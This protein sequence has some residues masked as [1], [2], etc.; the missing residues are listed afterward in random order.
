CSGADPAMCQ[1]VLIGYSMGGTVVRLQVTYSESI[2]WDTFSR[3]PLDQIK[4]P[5]DVRQRLAQD[6]YFEPLPFVTEAIY[7]AGTQLGPTPAAAVA[8]RIGAISTRFE[9]ERQQEFRS[10]RRENPLTLKRVPPVFDGIPSSMDLM[11]RHSRTQEAAY[12]LPNADWITTH[13]II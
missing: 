7:I 13:D 6:F 1:W 5:E 12:R 11:R 8:F 10:L 3:K 9:R 2:L 4:A